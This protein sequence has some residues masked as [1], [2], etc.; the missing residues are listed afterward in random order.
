M[1]KRETRYFKRIR[2]EKL[3][4]RIGG[5][6]D[7]YILVCLKMQQL[8]SKMVVGKPIE[9]LELIKDFHKQELELQML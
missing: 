1:T 6:V 5:I 8:R 2:K 3:F 9:E 4:G 7:S